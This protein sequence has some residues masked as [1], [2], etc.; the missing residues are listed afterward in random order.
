MGNKIE[1]RNSNRH[2]YANVHYDTIQNNQKVGS[3]QVPN[4]WMDIQTVVCPY[5]SIL[6]SHEKKEQ[7]CDTWYNNLENST[8]NPISQTQKDKYHMAPLKYL[9]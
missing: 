7:S 2:L 3:M 8:P 1:N 6:F 5:S 4:K 9:E